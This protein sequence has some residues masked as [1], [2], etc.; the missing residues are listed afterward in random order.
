MG[1]LRAD[2]GKIEFVTRFRKSQWLTSPVTIRFRAATT[3]N[4]HRPD[5]RERFEIDIG[6]VIILVQ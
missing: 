5:M 2:G 1:G 4:K 6:A 3:E